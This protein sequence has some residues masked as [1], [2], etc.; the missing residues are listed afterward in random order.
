MVSHRSYNVNPKA[1][2]SR[3][4]HSLHR[5]LNLSR[6]SISLQ[7]DLDPGGAISLKRGYLNQVAQ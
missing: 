5:V 2:H 4:D 1:L 7:L 6:C 3:Q